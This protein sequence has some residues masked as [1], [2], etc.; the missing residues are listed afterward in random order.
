MCWWVVVGVVV[1][2]RCGGTAD[3]R[4]EGERALPGKALS[5]PKPNQNQRS[6]STNGK[7]L[8]D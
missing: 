2:G 4:V 6:Q 1:E 7:L 3:L 5:K 8:A